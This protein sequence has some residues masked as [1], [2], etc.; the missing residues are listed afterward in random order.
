MHFCRLGGG[1]TDK[2]KKCQGA[3]LLDELVTGVRS[4]R[5]ACLQ[6]LTH[7]H[8]LTIQLSVQ[9]TSYQLTPA[10]HAVQPVQSDSVVF[11]LIIVT[12]VIWISP[13]V[14]AEVLFDVQRHL[15]K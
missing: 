6:T 2:Q 14:A 7:T 11:I 5:A 8:T 13:C 15:L 10:R 3:T 9:I 1:K 12:I 4:C